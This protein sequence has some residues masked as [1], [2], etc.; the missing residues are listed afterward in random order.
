M[1]AVEETEE[2][3]ALEVHQHRLTVLQS[4][5]AYLVVAQHQHQQAA[6]AVAAVAA[7]AVPQAKTLVALAAAAAVAAA[8][9]QL[10]VLLLATNVYQHL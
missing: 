9:Q 3:A 10:H 4:S 8:V 5:M 2:L 1:L 6:L 7:A